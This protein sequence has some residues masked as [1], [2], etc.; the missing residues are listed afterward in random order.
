MRIYSSPDVVVDE[1]KPGC[2]VVNS[3][4]WERSR[5]EVPLALAHLPHGGLADSITAAQIFSQAET[6]KLF[7]IDGSAMG[8]AEKYPFDRTERIRLRSSFS[9]NRFAATWT[10]FQDTPIVRFR[11]CCAISASVLHRMSSSSHQ[12]LQR[13]LVR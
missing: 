4:H 12:L 1:Q 3:K 9:S 5:I 7:R 11:S 13:L 2:L 6:A 10:I 8:A